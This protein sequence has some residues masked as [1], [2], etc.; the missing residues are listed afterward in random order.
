MDSS[1]RSQSINTILRSVE[2]AGPCGVVALVSVVK[3]TILSDSIQDDHQLLYH[4]L[5]T[6][7]NY[8]DILKLW[9]HSVV[10]S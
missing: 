6:D 2:S 3:Q 9:L 4:Q 8:K 5:S 1:H 10:I 7:T